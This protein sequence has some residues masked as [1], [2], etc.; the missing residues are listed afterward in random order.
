MNQY[1]DMLAVI[2]CA[3][4]AILA[5]IS[6]LR[7]SKEFAEAKN[8]VI[9]AKDAQIEMLKFEIENLRHLNPEKLRQYYVSMKN[10]LEEYNEKLHR[11]LS[12][13]LA[14][15]EKKNTE[16]DSLKHPAIIKT[17]AIIKIEK[18]EL[19]KNFYKEKV[20]LLQQQETD[21]KKTSKLFREIAREFDSSV[22]I[23]QDSRKPL[24]ISINDL[25]RNRYH[26]KPL[27]KSPL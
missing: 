25:R 17:P 3:I 7:W 6:K 12:S 9:A 8:Q 5:W 10:Q 21:L 23:I 24:P 18:L 15:L 16:I 14:E 11:E 4:A 13:A 26:N 19:E 20:E 1:I 22:E 2:V 27:K